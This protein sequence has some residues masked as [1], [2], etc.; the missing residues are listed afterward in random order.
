MFGS[1]GATYYVVVSNSTQPQHKQ[2]NTTQHN[3]LCSG[4]QLNT[5]F[6]IGRKKRRLT[7]NLLRKPLALALGGAL[8][9]RGKARAH[10]SGPTRCF[11]SLARTRSF[12]TQ[13]TKL[14]VRGIHSRV[15]SV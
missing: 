4:K 12:E 8:H 6:A 9:H 5:G 15:S 7:C 3:L 1:R 2:L 14:D 10:E 13:K 11:P